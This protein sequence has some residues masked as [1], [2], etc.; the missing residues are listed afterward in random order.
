M[1]EVK[2]KVFEGIDDLKVV[3]KVLEM[4]KNFDDKKLIDVGEVEKV[5]V[6]MCKIFDE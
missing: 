2:L 4:V 5:K 6:E 1:V 3:I